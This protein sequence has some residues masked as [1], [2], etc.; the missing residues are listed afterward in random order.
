MEQKKS[1]LRIKKDAR[2][3]REEEN[4]FWEAYRNDPLWQEWA[5]ALD[6]AAMRAFKSMS[7]EITWT[8]DNEKRVEER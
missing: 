6:R 3:L 1:R 2:I 7:P 5:N 4:E 8:D